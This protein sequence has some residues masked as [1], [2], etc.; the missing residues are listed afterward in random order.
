MALT[1]E[2]TTFTRDIVGRYLCNTFAEATQSGPFDVVIVGGG[3]FG[4]ALAQE[5]FFRSSPGQFKPNNFRILVLEAGP[6]SLLEHVQDISNLQLASP[7]A[8]ADITPIP[9]PTPTAPLP[10]TLQLLAQQGLDRRPL[11]ENWGLPWESNVVFGGLAY[12]LGGRSLYFGGWSPQYLDTEMHTVPVGAITAD[13]LWPEPV[14]QD[15]QVRFFAEAAP[16][17][18]LAPSLPTTTS[19]VTCTI[20]FANGC[21]TTTGPSPITCRSQTFPI[22]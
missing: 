1:T 10:S 2:S 16:Q 18:R 14:V 11:F 7:G 9:V 5:L 17:S 12:T 13:T 4:L 21:S 22:T 15:L 20:F 6:F 19:T 3:T 8:A